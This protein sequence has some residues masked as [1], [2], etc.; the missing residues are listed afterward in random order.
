MGL[1]LIMLG[2]H[3][4]ASI[5]DIGQFQSALTKAVRVS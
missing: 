3:G 5:L 1:A 4:L 2:R